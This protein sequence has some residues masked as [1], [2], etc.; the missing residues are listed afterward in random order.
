MALGK[1]GAGS[2]LIKT[3]PVGGW[4]E[5]TNFETSLNKRK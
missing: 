1:V 2:S 4:S 3:L 5:L